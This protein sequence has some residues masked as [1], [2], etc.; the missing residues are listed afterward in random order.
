[1]KKSIIHKLSPFNN[2]TDMSSGLLVVKKLLAFFLCYAAGMLAGNL[3][4]IGIMAACGKDL[5]QG[6]TFGDSVMELLGLYGMIAM[7]AAAVLYRKLIEKK[8]PSETGIAKN[9]GSWLMGAAM[10]AGL[11]FVCI[12]VIMLTGSITY[13]GISTAFD[14]KMSVLLLGGYAVQSSAEEFLCRGLVFGSLKDK[15]SL[16]LA[17][18][19]NTFA[20]IIPHL[21]TLSASEPVYMISGILCLIVISCVFSFITLR[22]G[23]IWAACGLHT[24][25]NYFLA[26]VLGLDLSGS[27]GTASSVINLRTAGESL[28]NGGRYGIEAS[29]LTAAVTAAAAV[30]LWY[31]CKKNNTERQ[32][33]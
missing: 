1:M 15:V 18:A 9:A 3:I 26:C 21:S 28:L 14:V 12:V 27:Q 8:K 29:L 22:T 33:G 11:L 4:I 10:G 6:E 5:S 30:L 23:S 31:S 25:W 2:D 19:A 7:I 13:E 20:F 24:L 16:P 17:V 32:E